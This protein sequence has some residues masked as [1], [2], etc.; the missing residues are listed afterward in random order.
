MSQQKSKWENVLTVK[1]SKDK[2]GNFV[3]KDGKQQFYATFTKD[4]SFKKGE[5][6]SLFP[7]SK[8]NKQALVSSGRLSQEIVDRII[9]ESV[10]DGARKVTQ[11]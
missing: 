6:V 1:K 7:V 10:F 11:N 5:S 3:Q 2:E 8:E 4:V 9:E